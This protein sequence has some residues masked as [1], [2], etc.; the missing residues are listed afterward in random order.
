MCRNRHPNINIEDENPYSDI[1]LDELP[2][3]WRRAVKEFRS[4]G[5]RPYHPPVFED[6]TYKHCVVD[7]LE[8]RIGCRI[9]FIGTEVPNSDEW[10]VRI[11]NNPIGA[12]G[13]H[14]DPS[15]YSIYEIDSEEFRRWI[16]D[17]VQSESI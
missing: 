10:L 4:H 8:E 1:D 3:W 16:L 13:H 2:L 6:G 12:V 17:Y 14:R 15:G 11:N 7:N 5:L 9:D